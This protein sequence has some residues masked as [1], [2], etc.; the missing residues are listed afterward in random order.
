MI[1]WPAP[2]ELEAGLLQAL[3]EEAHI[4]AQP[5]AQLV[6][7]GGQ[8]DRLLRA[9]DHRRGDGVG[10]EI[11]PRALAEQFDDLLAAGGEAA[12]RAAE[13]LAQRRR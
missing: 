9:G 8:L 2:A 13:R 4:V 10:E 1:G 6:A 5:G 12:G 7:G 3:A 11:G